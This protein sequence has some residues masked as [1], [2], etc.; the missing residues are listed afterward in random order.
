[1]R[2]Y[3]MAG[4]GPVTPPPGSF[5]LSRIAGLVGWFVWL[6]QLLSG[7]GSRW[8]HAWLVLDDGEIIEGQPGGARIERLAARYA[9]R[10]VVY[11]DR[12][13][14][15]AVAAWRADQAVRGNVITH[16]ELA[17]YEA[18]LRA[19]VVATGRQFAATPY[20]YLNYPYIGLRR[21]GVS[22]EWLR[23]RI[24][25][26]GTLICSQLVDAAFMETG[27]H[28]FDDGRWSGE[29]TPGDLHHYAEDS[30]VPIV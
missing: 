13:V 14:T 27:I 29:V 20:G 2:A 25:D 8:T 5:G 24:Q 23:R 4:A 6:G 10:E 19:R 7:D 11:T 18:S 22:P 26:Q 1:M 15:D 17:R 28:L 12:P 9:H 16:R 3:S 21:L 30:L